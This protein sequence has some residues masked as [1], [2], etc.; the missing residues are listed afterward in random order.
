[1]HPL[2]NIALRAGRDAAGLL[3]QQSER[4]D[5]IRIVETEAGR[6]ITSVEADADK[7]MLY[8]IRSAYPGHNIN[9]RISGE[10]TGGQGEPI[11][12]LDPAIGFANFLHGFPAFGVAI[13]IE[14]NK[15]VCHA[16]IVFPILQEEFTCSRG[17]GAQLN[18]RRLRVQSGDELKNT[19]I[20]VNPDELDAALL[21]GLISE[22]RNKEGQFRALGDT[23]LDILQVAAGRYNGGWG[24]ASSEPALRAALL[25]LREAGGIAGTHSGRPSPGADDE[26]LFANPKLLKQLLKLRNKFN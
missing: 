24:R 10:H 3:A 20:G 17:N 5:R 21:A 12:H 13:A 23:T 4:L 11:W 2:V 26:L 15:Q 14:L 22:L 19:L 9:S 25:V 6:K 8:H 18:A 7:S 1:M 16:T